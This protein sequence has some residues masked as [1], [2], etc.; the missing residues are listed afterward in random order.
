METSNICKCQK[1]QKQKLASLESQPISNNK[2]GDVFKNGNVFHHWL[3]FPPDN[4][5]RN[6]YIKVYMFLTEMGSLSAIK[7]IPHQIAP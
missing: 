5:Q 4:S 6:M 7:A 1:Y 2:N 3:A